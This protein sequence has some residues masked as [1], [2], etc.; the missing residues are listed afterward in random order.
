MTKSLFVMHKRFIDLVYPQNV[1][2][3]IKKLSDEV[4]PPM[5]ADELL[6]NK[7]IL[8]DVE[9]LFSGWGGP[10]FDKELLD[11][12]PHLKAIFY[13]AGTIKS[14]VTEEFWERNIKITSAY[15]ANAVPV[16]E[17]TLSQ[18]LFSLK[19]GW[20]FVKE[21]KE[22]RKYPPKPFHHIAGGYG[23]TV[24]LISLSTIGRK[25]NNLLQNF[26]VEI[27][28]YD[29]F[30]NTEEAAQLNV[31]LCSLHEIFERS[32]VV[33]LHTPL[34]PETVGM[35]TGEHF[36][37]MKNDATFINTARGAII[38]ENELIEVLKERPDLTAILDVTYPEPPT[39]D[40]P[41]YDLSNA[42]ITPHIAGSEGP[43]C[44]R[45]G[46]YMLSEF[47]RYL[48]G[49]QLKWEVSKEKFKTMA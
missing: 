3:E 48:N 8:K 6:K 25:V 13:A 11:A 39:K 18:I 29:P 14:I 19:S 28:A 47:K 27:L 20:K 15:E 31:E 24:G 22:N 10:T 43:E 9:V 21:V 35:I 36:Q 5:T 17:Y 32:D 34:L 2:E 30:V 49:E 26:D 40:S 16:A 37:V 12:F 38:K 1:T 41:L 33:S 23:S 45:M 42:I 7:S 4:A 44:G 46:A